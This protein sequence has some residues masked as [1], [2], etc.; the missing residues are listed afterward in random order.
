MTSSPGSPKRFARSKNGC[1]TCRTRKLK[2][3]EIAPVCGRCSKA[4]LKC[5]WNQ[6][7]KRTPKAIST[8][9][10]ATPKPLAPAIAIAAHPS[11]CSTQSVV[12]DPGR[13]P[14]SSLPSSR[15]ELETPTSSPLQ[16]AP[17]PLA[18]AHIPLSNSLGLA[19]QDLEALLFVRNSI[20]VLRF[21]KPFQWSIMSYVYHNIAGKYAGV[22]RIFIAG[23]NM[24]LRSKALLDY[25]DG[26]AS[27]DLLDNARMREHSAT[28]HYHLALKDL[29]ALLEH[30]SSQ[31]GRGSDDDV[32]AL[33]GMWFLILHFGL[34]DSHNI[35]AS[36]V[37]LEGIRSFLKPYLKSCQ[38]Q[39]NAT[40]PLVSQQLL[41]FISFMDN[42]LA[43]RSG[44]ITG[45]RL[46]LD[47]LSEDPDSPISYDA[48]F[49]SARSCL[50][51]LW[52]AQYPVSELLDDMENYRPLYFLHRCQKP[53]LDILRL[54][55][56]SNLGLNDAEG[57]QHLWKELTKLGDEFADV[58][59]LADK[60]TNSGSRRMIWTVYHAAL[61]YYAL[62]VLYSCLD[63]SD[64]NP[65][66]LDQVV[67]SATNIGHKAI[68]EDPRQLYRLV[69]PLAIA[70]VRTKDMIHRDWLKEQLL[71]AQILLPSFGS[72]NPDWDSSSVLG[73]LLTEAI[74]TCRT[75][76]LSAEESLVQR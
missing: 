65:P 61:E 11:P 63:P 7:A 24:E 66:W 56:T 38:R 34:C 44:S 16:N 71:R 13:G 68:R 40:L 21:G 32:N 51:K 46:W 75:V 64:E 18:A 62:H 4:N 47:L 48:L 30:V 9:T 25:R 2:C 10:S 43:L 17:S 14:L 60:V 5:G 23:A 72:L 27:S 49:Y 1:T 39:G 57:R 20:M 29:S 76:E 55:T 36:H 53:K 33:F 12:S 52:G 69:W 74:S 70:M 6:P 45:G 58:L 22:M 3:D 19:P 28:T 37:H 26:V 42:Y 8:L 59:S 41:Y 73:Q 54:T 31:G 35:G 15:Y 50:S 67:T